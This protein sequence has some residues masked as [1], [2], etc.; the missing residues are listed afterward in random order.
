MKS[1]ARCFFL[2]RAFYLGS[3]PIFPSQPLPLVLYINQTQNL[4]GIIDRFLASLLGGGKN[5]KDVKELE[6]VVQQINQAWEPL[7]SLSNDAFRSKVTDLKLAIRKEIEGHQSAIDALVSKAESGNASDA[8]KEQ[9]YE[10]VDKEERLLQETLKNALEKAL[11]QAFAFVK[12][13]A[14]RFKNNPEIRVKANDFDRSIAANKSYIRIEGNG[15]EATAIWPNRWPAA[16]NEIVWDMLHYDVQLIGGMALHQGKIAE[17][18]T[19]EGK[20][21]VATLPIFLNALS[22][23]GVHVVTVNDYLARRDS[24]WMGP[25]FEFHGLTIDC[26]DRHQPNSDARR[27]AYCADVVYGTNNEFGFDYLRDNM[28]T[29]LDQLVQRA[30][31]FAI[32]DEVDSVLIDEARTP[33]IISGPTPRGENQEFLQLKPLVEKL[34]AVQKKLINTQLSDAKRILNTE[35]ASKDEKWKASEYLL[36]AHRGLPKNSALIKFL[37]ESGMRAMLQKTENH[38]LQDQQKEMPKI[39]DELFF[40]ID[41]KGNSVDLTE[42]GLQ[43]ISQGFDDENFFLIPDIAAEFSQIDTQYPDPQQKLQKKDELMRD[44]T[45]K[46]ERIHTVNQLVRAYTLFEKDTEYVVMEGKVKIVDEQTGR[47]MDGRRYSDGLHQAIEAKENVKIEAATQTYATITLQNYFR[48]YQKL[49]GMTGTAETEAKELWDIYKLDVVVIPTHRNIQRKDQDDLVYKSK[50]EKYNATIDKVK[51]YVDAGRP[52]LVGTTSVEISELLSRMLKMANI[53]HQVLNAKLHQ[54]EAEIVAEAGK[55][56]TVT[57]ATNMAG[58]GTD[59]KLGPGVKDAGGLAII[60]TERH[61]SRRVDRQLRGR[62]GRQ[63]D[64]GSSVFFVSLEDDL[65]R[66]FGSERMAKIMDRM[67][68]KEGEV[69]THSMIT[70]SIERAQKKVEENNF[71]TRKRLLEYDDVMNLQREAIYKRRRNALYGKRIS[72]DVSNMLYDLCDQVVELGY[73]NRNIEEFRMEALRK[74]GVDS[75]V[76]EAEF[77]DGQAE[78]QAARLFEEAHSGLTRRMEGIRT[79][80]W[81]VLERVYLDEGSKFENIMVPLTDGQR[82]IQISV[83]LKKA[84]ENQGREIITTIQKSI[85]LALIDLHWKEHLR[86]MDDLKS[87]SH[88]ASYE[89]KDPLL[90][91]KQEGF[92]LFQSFLAKLNDEVLSFLLRAGIAQDRPAAP[93]RPAPTPAPLKASK[94]DLPSTNALPVPSASDELPKMPVRTDEKIGRNDPCPCGSGKKFKS[95]H[96][97]KI[98][99]VGYSGSFLN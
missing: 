76:T 93:A 58:R 34:A 3:L 89:Q 84:Y 70:R 41:E 4:M 40:V 87:S 99:G 78:E 55:A 79:A 33:L 24:E 97:Q 72:L 27:Q 9:I 28:A 92:G 54:K 19:G 11:P 66:I 35:N 45:I 15:D 22:G 71:G 5:R 98:G 30:H 53:K 42:K 20:T 1:T 52:V 63:G 23:R 61:E 12:E 81:P 67:G 91:Y 62:S 50:R 65:M 17:M 64:P 94:P 83:P 74:L 25:I 73:K 56:G 8:E 95:C 14:N 75:S 26:I 32:I 10:L 86:E 68:L 69:I 18:A 88:H 90:V 2:F 49:A 80:V 13:T 47:I 38:F 46:S 29:H 59:I 7:Q 77:L 31:Q 60:G 48:M 36:R 44:F 39:D 96:G 21:L 82:M 37:S 51:E 16:G 57:I 85:I 43:L 6:V